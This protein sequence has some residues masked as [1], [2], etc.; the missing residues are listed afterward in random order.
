MSFKTFK[1]HKRLH[2]D[3]SSGKW[4]VS[5]A[6][7]VPLSFE[8]KTYDEDAPSSLGLRLEEAISANTDLM[9]PSS[10]FNG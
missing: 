4:Q 8:S 1:A 9:P 6:S 10:Q 2:F 3:V 7:P 5:S